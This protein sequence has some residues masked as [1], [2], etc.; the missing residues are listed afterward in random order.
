VRPRTEE[1]KVSK[2]IFDIS[3]S[4]DGF[5]TA[6]GVRPGE[7]MG[8]GGQK[9]HEWAH[10]D[11]EKGNEVLAESQGAFGASIAGRRSYDTSL[12]WWDADGPEGSVRT[13]T[14][15][16]SRSEPDEVPE[17]SVY[18]FVGSPEEAVEKAT[19]MAGGKDVD[20]F[21]PSIGRHLLR[22]GLVDEIRM[23]LVPVL[24]GAGTRLFEN[25]GGE[26]IRLEAAEVVETAATH[27]RFR[28]LG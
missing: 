3:M 21:S 15:I 11:D 10:G 17:G 6:S 18:T 20:V 28:I 4:L 2:V 27:I 14:F 23:H 13:P 12:P 26:Q 25:A 24:L 19:E 7:P 16:V 9:L 8:D 5:V 1:A 22:A